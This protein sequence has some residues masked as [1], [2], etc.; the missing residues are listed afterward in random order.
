MCPRS[1]VKTRQL[2]F[3]TQQIHKGQQLV[4]ALWNL[5][6]LKF[7][8]SSLLLSLWPKQITIKIYMKRILPYLQRSSKNITIL[9]FGMVIESH[10]EH[11]SRPN[12]MINISEW[13]RCFL[14][15]TTARK[16]KAVIHATRLLK[17]FYVLFVAGF[18]KLSYCKWNNAFFNFF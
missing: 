2:V 15:Q 16:A 12:Y 8:W 13:E 1:N 18:Y 5:W 17:V 9:I 6:L 3:K 7:N 11:N 10:Q 4:L 14:I